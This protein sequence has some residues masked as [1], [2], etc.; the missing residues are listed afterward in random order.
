MAK[1]KEIKEAA[2]PWDPADYLSDQEDCVI[3]L[4]AC[5]EEGDP[6]VIIAALGAVARARGIATLAEQTG[7][8]RQGLY[9]ALR[10]DGN[11][12]F[13]AVLKIIRALGMRLH[14][15]AA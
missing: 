13:A 3:F 14:I 6:S 9:K 7:M 10:E 12:S 11:P 15:E 8:S 5:V 4:E 2:T 1:G